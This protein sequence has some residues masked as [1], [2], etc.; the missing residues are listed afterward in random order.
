LQLGIANSWELDKQFQMLDTPGGH[1]LWDVNYT[2]M[3]NLAQYGVSR[4][5]CYCPSNPKQNTDDK[6]YLNGPSGYHCTGYWW[7]VPRVDANGTI[8]G[9][10]PSFWPTYTDVATNYTD[11]INARSSKH[12]ILADAVISDPSGKFTDVTGL[13]AHDSPHLGPDRRPEGA[14]VCFAD[15]HVVW[16][17]FNEL[18]SRLNWNPLHWW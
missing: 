8:V 4:A 2:T 13:L 15:G 10:W 17:P 6:W 11:M 16:R 7:V 12:V 14:N 1:W 3:S 9:G 18:R 5:I